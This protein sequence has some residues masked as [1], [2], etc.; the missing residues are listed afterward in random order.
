MYNKN[1]VLGLSH[2]GCSLIRKGIKAEKDSIVVQRLKKAGLI[3]LLVSNTPEY[4]CSME[5]YNK[6]VGFTYNPY[7]TRYTSGGSSGGEVS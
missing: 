3:P 2:T 7:N 6:L 1:E 4:S 5:T